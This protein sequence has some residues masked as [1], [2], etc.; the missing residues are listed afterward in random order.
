MPEWI[1]NDDGG[2]YCSQCGFFIDDYYLAEMP[3]QCEKC[4][5]R[6]S[7]NTTF[8]VDRDY[9]LSRLG[10]IEYC[11]DAEYPKWLLDLRIEKERKDT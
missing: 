3:K 10:E 11:D 4:G 1:H 6:L 8:T 2:Y 9:R 7:E 5:T